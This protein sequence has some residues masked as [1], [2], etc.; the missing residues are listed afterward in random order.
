MNDCWKKKIKFN[1]YSSVLNLTRMQML[2]EKIKN[3]CWKWKQFLKMLE[4][5]EIH[6]EEENVE[7]EDHQ[8]L[9][10]TFWG[11][12]CWYPLEDLYLTTC[13][14][15]DTFLDTSQNVNDSFGCSKKKKIFWKGQ[16]VE[17][18]YHLLLVPHLTHC[19]L[20]QIVF[21]KANRKSRKQIT[22]WKIKETE[23]FFILEVKY[24][25]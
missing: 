8:T 10:N 23:S 5:L 9:G 25:Y 19:E 6:F 18:G 1:G 17:T 20:P 22:F 12:E 11:R 7:N 3:N 15:R 13:C 21:T 14:R 4:Y 16:N 24:K 2:S